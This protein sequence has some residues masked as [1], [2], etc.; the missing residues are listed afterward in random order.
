MKPA[1]VASL[2][3]GLAVVGVARGD[4][5]N[6]VYA[7][8]LEAKVWVNTDGEELSLAE[9]RGMVVVLFFWVSWHPGGEY[10]MPLMTQ[11]NGSRFGRSAGVYVI[12]V[13]D[14]E[15][16]RV[17]ELLK[18]EKVIF[19]V[20]TE[21]KKSIEDYDIDVYPCVVIVDANG[22]VAW[23]GRP[24]EDGGQ[25]LVDEI[26]RVVAETPPTK[27]HPEEAVKVH[28]YLK[29]AHR[30]LRDEDYHRAV[31]EGRRA[32][33][34]ALTGDSL[35]T[36]CQDMLDLIEALGRDTLARAERAADE[37]NF[38]EAVTLL[39]QIRRDFRGVAIARTAKQKLK[40]LKKK[41]SEVE[42]ILAQLENA[43]LAENILAAAMEELRSKP[44]KIGRAYERLE[45]IINEYGDTGTAEKAQL[46]LER[47]QD[48]DG[49]MEYVRDHQAAPE[50]RALL[51]Q[52]E[53]YERSG[54]L[55]KA[56]NL[57]RKV[58]DK[59]PDTIWADQAAEHLAQLL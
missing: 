27:T 36:R 16:A 28:A 58:I 15:R 3:L 38:E 32:L 6:G 55:N 54:R 20:G 41:Y 25:K 51:F 34:T 5:D 7:P 14:A 23:T 50:C 45:E 9:C 35:K 2:C 19:P 24:G 12:G 48:N 26:G 53:A 37:K 52:A 18:K 33:Q 31:Q 56:K 43:S 59:F 30:A 39:R 11:V 47:M 29:Q 40:T 1:V 42:D 17:E 8:D 4:L 57:Y 10:V 46:V 22:K 44:R 49:V 21:A 13:T